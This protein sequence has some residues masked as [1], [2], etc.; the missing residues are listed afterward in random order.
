MLQVV[1]L[2]YTR[3]PIL[4][5]VLYNYILVLYKYIQVLY[6]YILV[7]YNYILVLYNYIQVGI[8]ALGA[9]RL[10]CSNIYTSHVLRYPYYRVGFSVK[11]PLNIGYIHVSQS[12]TQP[13]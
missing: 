6:N 13:A 1:D 10:H 2:L 7:L 3:I 9:N 8:L 5:L 12:A 4:A 11:F